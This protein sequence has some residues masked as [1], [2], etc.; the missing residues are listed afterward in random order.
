MGMFGIPLLAAVL[1]SN[2]IYKNHVKSLA[3]KGFLFQNGEYKIRH[4]LWALV[5][6]IYL[7]HKDFD[8]DFASFDAMYN[9]KDMIS[10]ILNNIDSNYLLNILTRCAIFYKNEPL[11]PIAKV[12]IDN[13]FVPDHLDSTKKA[14]IYSFGLGNFY[15]FSEEHTKSLKFYNK[16]IEL[17]PNNAYAWINKGN[18]FY[19]LE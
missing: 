17:D 8:N 13:Y 3:A 19:K 9:I 18:A 5:F 7:Y 16:A 4:E 14:E 1:E 12:I 11:K 15:Y 10:S 6:L 2:C